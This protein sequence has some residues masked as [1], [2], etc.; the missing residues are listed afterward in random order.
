MSLRPSV[1]KLTAIPTA[2]LNML[3][4]GMVKFYRG[5]ISPMFPPG[6]P[7]HPPHARNMP[8]RH[9]AAMALCAA[10]GSP[11]AAF[12]DATPGAVLATTRCPD[13]TV[14]LSRNALG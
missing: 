11:C 14:R 4:I 6:M 1:K 13:A 9:C 8:S 5:A 10:H 3:L 7:L 12:C 2:A